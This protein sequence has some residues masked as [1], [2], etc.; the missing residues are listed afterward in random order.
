MLHHPKNAALLRASKKSFQQQDFLSSSLTTQMKQQRQHVAHPPQAGK[1]KKNLM[2]TARALQL[3][4]F[5]SNQKVTGTQ[6][7]NVANIHRI[8]KEIEIVWVFLKLGN[9]TIGLL[10]IRNS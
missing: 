10:M 7:K 6:W 5:G 1:L 9:P 8:T 2:E 3:G 4:Q